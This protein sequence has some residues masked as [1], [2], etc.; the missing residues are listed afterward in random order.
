MRIPIF[1]QIDEL[2]QATETLQQTVWN[3][4]HIYRNEDA[5][6]TCVN[7]MEP[8]R[9]NFFQLSIDL[10]S[11]Y[12][13]W[14]NTQ[15][16]H[17]ADNT[18]YFT[19]ADTLISWKVSNAAKT[20]KGYNINFKQDLLSAGVNNYNFRKEFPFLHSQGI[21]WLQLP[22]GNEQ[23]N[24]LC[25]RML[26][27]Q[28]HAARDINIIRHYLFVL[29]YT[30]KR[31]YARQH[32]MSQVKPLSREA[33]LAGSF[34]DL[35]NKFYLE[36]KSLNDYA[37]RLYVSSKYLSQVTKKV[38][39]KTAKEMILHRTAE[40]AKSLLV[41]TNDTLTQIASRLEFTDTSNFIKFFKRLT[42]QGPT[43]YRR[44]R[45]FLP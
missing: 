26:Y 13:L 45:N 40:E 17:T 9:C 21:S 18:I 29:L 12:S 41:Q 8:H 10:R 24:E 43:E 11:D 42:G 37:S 44:S 7:T 6:E 2:H 22:A 5:N 34:E 28:Q 25:E 36:Y 14:H 38:Y 16:L 27:E 1:Q 20:W 35:V 32:P 30:I 19:T 15:E 23:V 4:F 39:G 33:E 3:D 31:I